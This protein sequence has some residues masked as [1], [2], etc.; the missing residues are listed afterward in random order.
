V[1][2]QDYDP[3]GYFY[4]Q[5]DGRILT[6][7]K[8]SITGPG[9][10]NLVK[11][12]SSG[13]YQW[14]VDTPGTY[15]MAID[16]S[17]MEFDTIAQSSAG[18]MTIAS[19]SGNPVVIGSTQNADTGYLGQFNGTD[20][21][22]ANPTAY[23]TSFVI[24]E[25]D[26]N[27]F[28]NNI[29]FD[30]CAMNEVQVSATTQ[31][32]EPNDTST[33]D[34][35]FTVSMA[36]VSKVD[37]VITYTLSG[38]ATAGKDYTAPSG[39]VTIPAGET[40]ATVSIAILDDELSEGAETIILT[41]TA[42]SAGDSA[43][44]LAASPAAT[45]QIIEDLIDQIRDDLTEILNNDMRG[46][47]DGQQA[48]ISQTSKSALARL[49]AGN[50]TT[51]FCGDQTAP[52]TTGGATASAKAVDINAAQSTITYDC[53]S[54]TWIK[55]DASMRVTKTDGAGVQYNLGYSVQR[56]RFVSDTEVRGSFLGAY[57]SRSNVSG[58]ADGSIR[59]VGVNGGIFGAQD[60]AQGYLFDYYLGGSLSAHTFDLQ[61]PTAGRRLMQMGD[62]HTGH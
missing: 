32:V 14:F 25:G 16:T 51:G 4:C 7:G 24:A 47:I 21:D 41:L 42:I 55:R 9:N 44:I 34:A 11:D 26:P 28:G 62:T 33:Q 29:P 46:A 49:R 13:E 35:V 15:T 31:G 17:G 60:L 40:S 53:V 54:G 56:E 58:K 37:T 2:A 36:R 23:Y 6:G 12:G 10:I 8:V 19:F 22:P 50:D 48:V 43:T 59:G 5:A 30:G 52:D 38:T 27:G 39:T 1:D 20:Y 3:Q 45:A 61:F 57:A 18:S